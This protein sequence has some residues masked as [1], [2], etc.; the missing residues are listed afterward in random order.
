M[1]IEIQANMD[2]L[3]EPMDTSSRLGGMLL[4]ILSKYSYNVSSSIEGVSSSNTMNNISMTELFGGSRIENIFSKIYGKS[5]RDF[6]PLDG[7]SDEDIRTV[8]ANA[9][10][11][12]PALLVSIQSFD[13]L[14][15]TQISKLEYPGEYAMD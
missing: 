14:V 15:R 12:R 4:K 5:L 11:L 10:G 9:N 1:M 2:A 3:G 8:M 6:D 7:L 13:V